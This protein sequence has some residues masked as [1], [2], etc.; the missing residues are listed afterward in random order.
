M[1][2]GAAAA[3]AAGGGGGGGGSGSGGGGGGGGARDDG[4]GGGFESPAYVSLGTLLPNITELNLSFNALTRV[5]GLAS[6]RQ[7]KDL[8][9]AEN[10][11]TDLRGIADCFYSSAALAAAAAAAATT[12]TTNTAAAA[13]AAAMTASASS[14]Y[15]CPLERLNLSGNLLERIPNEVAALSRLTT[16]R[17][18]RNR[19]HVLQVAINVPCLLRF[20][21]TAHQ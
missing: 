6:L 21:S 12:P 17:L 7:L 1:G 10:S 8:N 11:I 3:A 5:D 2:A 20:C 13:A 19:L 18:R 9:L 14:D 15:S 4:T 16:L